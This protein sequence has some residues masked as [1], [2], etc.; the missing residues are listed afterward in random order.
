MGY[1][2]SSQDGA[3]WKGF[4][5]DQCFLCNVHTKGL[6]AFLF[7][8]RHCD[9]NKLSGN[10]SLDC[11]KMNHRTSLCSRVG[12][13]TFSSKCSLLVERRSSASMDWA[14]CSWGLD[15]LSMA[16][17]VLLL[18]PLWLLPLG[19]REGQCLCHH[20]PWAYLIW[21]RITVAVETITP[22][23]LIRVWQELD[24]RL[25]VCRVMKGAYIKHL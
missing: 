19:L 10:A 23:L 14:G 25:N 8:W 17:T 24:Y 22:D 15:V 1:W 21:N 18:N 3:T 2:K 6:W 4:P 7:P 20:N 13:T 11:W 12:F 5:K 9:R 16:C